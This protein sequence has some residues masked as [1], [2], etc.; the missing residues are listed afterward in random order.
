MKKILI[1]TSNAGKRKEILSALLPLAGIEIVIP[2]DLGL[3]L[4]IAE[5]GKDY[6]ENALIKAKA[7]FEK[8]GLPTIAE[9]SG[10]EVS[11]L[12]GELGMHTRR[13]GAGPKASDQ[14]W[15]DFF[16]K[17]M[18]KE[19][20]RSARFVCHAVYLDEKGP[21]HFEGQC[22]G[23]ITETVKGPVLPGIP[24]SAVFK[25]LGETL[26]YSAMTEEQKNTL[27]HRGKAIKMLRDWLLI[28]S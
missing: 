3:A 6:S 1:A 15:L 25:P 2:A 21:H 11:A 10:M 24:L 12:K 9:D 13:W 17:R 23:M 16:M 18:A 20:N 19:S 8:T 7:Y 27:S 26:V 5:N 28:S 4:N 22:V 14:E